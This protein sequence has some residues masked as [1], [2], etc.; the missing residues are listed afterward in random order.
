MKRRF[1]VSAKKIPAEE[2]DV[3]REHARS[4]R[5][6][7][8][9]EDVGPNAA[10]VGEEV[11]YATELDEEG[12]E[13]FS[14]ASNLRGLEPDET[15]RALSLPSGVESA[16][17]E[18]H[19]LYAL[20][21][22]SF[23]GQD[24]Y[25]CVGDTGLS[26]AVRKGHF[27]D[28]IE[29][30]WSWEGEGAGDL[31]GHGTWCCGAAVPSGS[32]L[33]VGKVLSDE[34]SGSRSNIVALIYRFARSMSQRR[35]RGVLS[36]SLG[37]PGYSEAY[38]EAIRYALRRGVLV[39]CAAGNDGP[40][41]AVGA[42]GNC[43]SAVTVAAYDHRRG[44]IASFSSR[45]PEVDVAAAGVSVAG[46]GLDGSETRLSGTSMATPC[47]ARILAC[48]LSTGC[49][50]GEARKALLAGA[51]DT[52]EPVTHEGMGVARAHVSFVKLGGPAEDRVSPGARKEK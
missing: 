4:Y 43:E 2:R 20:G 13:A 25:V 8:G 12:V 35:R 3:Y 18:F 37:G 17:L 16:V 32:R 36:L 21:R 45:G 40:N 27:R 51:R 9:S 6:I 48:L 34:G 41:G 29:A 30:N 49:S 11:V 33:I 14:R 1:I 28:R 15:D 52:G 22:E 23:F 42:P 46:F 10:G 44:Q 5:E 7:H 39:V 50:V 38:E 47:I 24:V 26:D 31:H 19:E